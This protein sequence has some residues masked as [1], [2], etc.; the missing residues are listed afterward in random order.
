MRLK[1]HVKVIKVVGA[2]E[3]NQKYR[4]IVKQFW[5]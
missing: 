3:Y 4:M 5:G 1:V 2:Y